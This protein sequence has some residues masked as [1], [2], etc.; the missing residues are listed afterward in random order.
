MIP[1]GLLVALADALFFSV[2]ALDVS[3]QGFIRVLGRQYLDNRFN[4]ALLEL[5]R[6][7]LEH[8]GKIPPVVNFANHAIFWVRV[9]QFLKQFSD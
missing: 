3:L 8:S 6:N 1:L 5:L 7:C 9:S 4:K 2:K